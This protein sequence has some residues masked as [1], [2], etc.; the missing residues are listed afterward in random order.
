MMFQEVNCNVS[1]GKFALAK[2]HI[3]KLKYTCVL[4]A[5]W[6]K[7]MLNKKMNTVNWGT[8]MQKASACAK[9]SL[10]TIN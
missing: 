10:T 1:M 9:Q 2:Y 8:C 3:A 7:G 5:H 6:L 4:V